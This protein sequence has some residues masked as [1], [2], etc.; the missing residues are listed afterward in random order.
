MSVFYEIAKHYDRLIEAGNDPVCDPISLRTYMDKWDGALFFEI[1]ALC[2][3]EK[4]L[5]IGVGSGRLA[6]RTAPLVK[7]F[8]GIDLSE[9]TIERARKH[10]QRFKNV[11]LYQGDF[12]DYKFDSAFDTI[13]ASL[14]FFHFQAKEK[15][16]DRVRELLR[17]G[18]RFVLSIDKNQSTILDMG[19]YKVQLHPDTKDKIL[20]LGTAQ[21][22]RL[23]ALCET[24]FAYIFRFDKEKELS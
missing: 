14:V 20:A 3:E 16:F 9:K 22:F 13:Y 10:L 1:L 17:P 15:A 23:E 4:V 19:S 5:E 12:L 7:E 6:I 8:H 2:P 18:G 21:G 24:E 11:S